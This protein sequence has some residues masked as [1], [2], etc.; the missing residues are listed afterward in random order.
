M[1]L[2]VA[3]ICVLGGRKKQTKACCW[4]MY[5]LETD[6][7]RGCVMI[8]KSIRNFNPWTF[9]RPFY[10][11][12]ANQF[13]AFA[14][15]DILFINLS[16]FLHFTPV[17]S[18]CLKLQPLLWIGI[19]RSLNCYL[20]LLNLFSDLSEILMQWCHTCLQSVCI[21]SLLLSPPHMVGAKHCSSFIATDH[22]GSISLW[23]GGMW[24]ALS[25]F[26]ALYR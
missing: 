7:W 24:K 9:T 16:F 10:L 8:N 22:F 12:L 25:T 3:G 4:Q 17:S 15:V 14:N 13:C 5:R 21:F 20:Q 6:Q 26:M 1:P 2:K 19:A 23:S 11:R 18:L